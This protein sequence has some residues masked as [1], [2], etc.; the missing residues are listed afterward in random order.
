LEGKHNGITV[1]YYDRKDRQFNPFWDS[2]CEGLEEASNT[3]VL[4]AVYY[5]LGVVSSF[6]T[7]GGLTVG[8]GLGSKW[9][10]DDPDSRT[11]FYV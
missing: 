1:V 8:K 5:R 10:A 2:M 4:H 7:W 11:N 3:Q 9:K 6:V